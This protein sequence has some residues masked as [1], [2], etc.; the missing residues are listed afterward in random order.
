[1][2][3]AGE[4]NGTVEELAKFGIGLLD[5]D[6]GL[7]LDSNTY[8]EL[9]TTTYTVNKDV[10]GVAHGFFE[11]DGE[12][13]AYWHNGETDNF[14]TFFAVVPEKKF[15]VAVVANTSGEAADELVHTVGRK[16]IQKK[17]IKL[18]D[19]EKH[20]P[21]ARKVCGSYS[22]PRCVHHGI[23]QLLYIS[24]TSDITVDYVGK[25]K[26]TIN[27]EAYQQVK[28]YLYQNMENGQMSYFTT[29]NGKVTKYTYLQGYQKNTWTNTVRYIGSYVVMIIF[30]ITL[31]SMIAYAIAMLV[32]RRTRE[33]KTIFISVFLWLLLCV[34]IVFITVSALDGARF[35]EIRPYILVNDAIAIGLIINYI[36]ELRTIKKITSKCKKIY[37]LLC[38]ISGLL[39]LIILGMWGVFNPYR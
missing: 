24:S 28:P 16:M 6:S 26:V 14:H 18:Y 30:V 39:M 21:D 31:V 8:D 11:F 36:I 4:G 5:K 2:Y 25:N 23:S 9:F 34:S 7:F 38:S 19:S 17:Q 22:A 37:Y 29:E 1:M 33:N 15:V 32:K 27:G 35:N 20:L 10:T 12:S 3:P 13:K